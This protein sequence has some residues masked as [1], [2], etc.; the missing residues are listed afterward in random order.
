MKIYVSIGMFSDN[1]EPDISCFK[2]KQECLIYIHDQVDT[3]AEDYGCDKNDIITGD[4]SCSIV[5]PQGHEITYV[6]RECILC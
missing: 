6:C 2:D 3:Y 1:D 4:E 5:T